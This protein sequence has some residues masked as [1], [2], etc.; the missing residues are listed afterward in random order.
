MRLYD[1]IFKSADGGA[2]ARC[3]LVPDGGGYFQGVKYV[4]DFSSEKIALCFSH[5]RVEIEGVGLSIVKYC[6]GDL[7]IGGKITAW[8][9]VSEKQAEQESK[10]GAKT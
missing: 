6:D 10:Q 5:K 7:E 4:E 8:R 1:E 3:I 9:V 2:L